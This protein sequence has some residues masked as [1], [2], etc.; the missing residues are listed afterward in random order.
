MLSERT[1]K[2]Q[3]E[4]LKFDNERKTAKFE[5]FPVPHLITTKVAGNMSFS[6]GSE[7]EVES[8]KQSI[9]ERIGVVK[10]EQV[11]HMLPQHRDDFKWVSEFNTGNLIK[12]DALITKTKGLALEVAPADC[13]SL[14]CYSLVEGA[15]EFAETL[16]LI[17]VSRKNVKSGIIESII[18]RISPGAR[19][20]FRLQVALAP[21][22][23]SCCYKF[24]L[25]KGISVSQLKRSDF[26]TSSM[27]SAFP[28][29]ITTVELRKEIMERLNE[30][31]IP[32]GNITF[33]PECTYCSVYK[34]RTTEKP[35]FFS[36]ERA[37]KTS[38]EEGRNLVLARLPNSDT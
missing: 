16:A 27:A 36:H 5:G 33:S 6:Y 12:C 4:E 29:W 22:I 10:P 19:S 23:G 13:Y 17:H 7:E 24:N 30:T 32:L 15:E 14:I 18:H 31:G 25:L 2:E 34:Q 21:G 3:S 1:L 20:N 28:S 37:K 35:L 8:N 38:E 11:I 9:Y 26:L